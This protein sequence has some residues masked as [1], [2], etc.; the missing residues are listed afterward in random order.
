VSGKH[1]TQ[2]LDERL[3]HGTTSQSNWKMTNQVT[4]LSLGF[5]EMHRRN[6]ENLGQLHCYAVEQGCI[7]VLLSITTQ[8]T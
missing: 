3:E 4:E 5:K 2:M 6:R 1:N 8:K 7:C